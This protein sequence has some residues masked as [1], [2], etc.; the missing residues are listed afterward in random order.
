VTKKAAHRGRGSSRDKAA[1]THP[2]GRYEVGAMYLPAQHRHLMPQNQEF[3]VLGPAVAGELGQ[4]LQ[5]L[6][7]QQVHQRS[8]HGP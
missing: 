7:D 3:D 2:V 6:A 4:H 5:H 8:A 1:N